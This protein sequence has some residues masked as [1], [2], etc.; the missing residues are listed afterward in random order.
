MVVGLGARGQ[1]GH[2][3]R[4]QVWDGS[5][6]GE[7]RSLQGWL[8]ADPEA[9]RSAAVDV[10][11]GVPGPGEMDGTRTRGYAWSACPPVRHG[12][13]L[14]AG[15]RMAQRQ[16]GAYDLAS[17]HQEARGKQHSSR[18]VPHDWSSLCGH[19]SP[20]ARTHVTGI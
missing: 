16:A 2:G 8:R 3:V 20:H 13:Q 5:A 1:G 19:G 9:R 10:R 7:L 4:L 12:V 6:T 11:G 18:R 15:R 17:Q 14:G